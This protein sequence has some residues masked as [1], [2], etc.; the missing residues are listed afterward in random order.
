M[1]YNPCRPAWLFLDGDDDG[2]FGCRL[3]A[4]LFK[5]AT[6]LLLNLPSLASTAL[7]RLIEI[8]SKSRIVTSSPTMGSEISL[9]NEAPT[10]ICLA[11]VGWFRC[12]A[13]ERMAIF[14]SF[15]SVDYGLTFCLSPSLEFVDHIDHDGIFNSCLVESDRQGKI[16]RQRG[17]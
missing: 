3:P 7:L 8:E 4:I 13:L 11:E 5:A 12:M 9:S 10:V 14:P 15:V 1:V 6:R 2:L 17:M 16:R